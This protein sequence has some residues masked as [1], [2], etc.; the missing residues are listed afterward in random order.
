MIK[1]FEEYNV[2]ESRTTFQI[3]SRTTEDA[4]AIENRVD[5]FNSRWNF[6]EHYIKGVSGYF[7]YEEGDVGVVVGDRVLVAEGD[8]DS[9][10]YTVDGRPES[11]IENYIQGAQGNPVV[12]MINFYENEL[13]L[14]KLKQ[15]ARIA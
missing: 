12:G 7:E 6:L 13:L 3:D 1:K 9:A 5:Q 8:F 4:T 15:A 10:N 11:R 14:P 2:N